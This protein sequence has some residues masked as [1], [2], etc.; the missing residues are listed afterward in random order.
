MPIRKVLAF[1][2]RWNLTGCISKVIL[3]HHV[4][5]AAF[6]GKSQIKDLTLYDLE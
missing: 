2:R 3:G 1:Y 4:K 5:I 6:F